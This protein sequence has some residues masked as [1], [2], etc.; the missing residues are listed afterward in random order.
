MKSGYQYREAIKNRFSFIKLL[1]T[2]LWALIIT[3]SISLF[4]KSTADGRNGEI[5]TE[6]VVLP[7]DTLWDIS[8]DNVTG[9]NLQKVVTKIM[10]MNNL[11]GPDIYPGQILRIPV[12]F[13]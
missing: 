9:E 3:M 7:G 1:K 11:D 12:S 2:L 4:F 5:F 6:V 10:K 13:R 8:R